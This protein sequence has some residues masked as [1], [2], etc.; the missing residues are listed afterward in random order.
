[1]S[2]RAQLI[3]D[4]IQREV[5]A[6]GWPVGDV[7]GSESDL[8][9]RFGVSRS[10]LREAV[11]ILESQQVATMR[12]GSN[13]GLTITMPDESVVVG[14][15]ARHFAHQEVTASEL[16]EARVLVELRC[17]ELVA[18]KMD[19]ARAEALRR[20]IAET[21][22][23]PDADTALQFHLLL[24]ELSGNRVLALFGATLAQLGSSR[25][26]G[27]VPDGPPPALDPVLGEEVVSVHERI[28]TAL[29]E[30]D[31]GLARARAM[32]HLRHMEHYWTC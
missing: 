30:G 23:H 15:V 11:R 12:P 7:L 13:G 10:T 28:V 31:L 9:Q 3:A 22:A 1:M 14:S 19:E 6:R 29:I 4:E 20:Q 32:G 16:L 25:W 27:G 2:K 21:K 26:A 24:G 8:T 5:I 18:E 17:V